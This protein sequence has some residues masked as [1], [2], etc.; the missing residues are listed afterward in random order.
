[1][2]TLFAEAHNKKLS[3]Q[4]CPIAKYSPFPSIVV[5][6]Y[7]SGGNRQNNLPKPAVDVAS[8]H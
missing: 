5:Y 3:M 8:L 4:K 2:C 1:M 7:M 6:H